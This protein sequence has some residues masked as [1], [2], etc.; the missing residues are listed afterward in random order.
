MSIPEQWF[1]PAH[2]MLEMLAIFVAWII[3]LL[4]WNAYTPNRPR[5]IIFLSCSLLSVGVLD[6]FH[7]MSYDGMPPLITANNPHK[8]IVFSLAARMVAILALGLAV[9]LPWKRFR[10]RSSRYLCLL[11]SLCLCVGLI[12]LILY[13]ASW[14]PVTITEG[15]GLT[16]FKIGIEAAFA[17]ILL[18]IMI[19]LLTTGSRRIEGIHK[20][21][22]VTAIGCML[23][24]QSC[25]IFYDGTT[26]AMNVVG[27]LLKVISYYY[28]YR[29][30]ETCRAT[31]HSMEEA[32]TQ[33][34]RLEELQARKN[35][36]LEGT[37]DFISIANAQGELLYCNETARNILGLESPLPP[38]RTIDQAFPQW[39]FEQVV[40]EGLPAAIRDGVWHGET[41]LLDKAGKQ[42]PVSQTIAAHKN[43]EGQVEYFSTICRDITERKQ[44]E[45][46]DKLSAR[47]F[48]C[49]REGFMVTDAKHAILQV[50]PACVAITGYEESE[51]LGNTP[52]ML[53]S[54]W[55]KSDFYDGMRHSI[56]ETG[57]W[58]GQMWNKHK[59]GDYYLIEI[60][61]SKVSDQ[62]FE[63]YIAV[64]K[65]ITEKQQLEAKLTH[66][67]S[68]DILTGLPN[69]ETLA[70]RFEQAVQ[71]VENQNLVICL[72]HL[73]IDNLKQVNAELGH[74]VGDQLLRM[75]AERLKQSARAS[76]T[77]ARISGDEFVIL[78][79]DLR[80]QED[81]IRVVDRTRET[82][83][84]PFEVASQHIT[85][86]F[87]IGTCFYPDHGVTLDALIMNANP[88]LRQSTR[89]LQGQ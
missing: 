5:N 39:A 32:M 6:L 22:L 43:G 54:G 53:S 18:F 26:D 30:F 17:A 25:F 51:V 59:N 61:I 44:I 81:Y 84:P 70:I 83:S 57:H 69:R 80:R 7:M 40:K 13:R 65:D 28:I 29:S 15:N 67:A 86:A 4:G 76:S 34:M 64:F 89:T 35:S 12:A 31:I 46:R 42:I 33:H 11:A 37:S 16:P 56:F 78:L 50:N 24:G 36:I 9:F 75:I 74:S 52:R 66:Q 82:L 88:A 10:Y 55:H 49:A 2:S 85:I 45:Q 58:S 63:Y 68:H 73:D 77:V 21:S 41:A 1:L 27:H 60:T 48:E 38:H 72:M 20:G 14:I 19:S 62:S 3:F 87:S 23:L 79:P 71:Y 47:L 8:A